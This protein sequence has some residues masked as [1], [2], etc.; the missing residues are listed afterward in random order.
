V[1]MCGLVC[2]VVCGCEVCVGMCGVCLVWVGGLLWEGGC[3]WL[4]V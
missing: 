2:G 4:C 3:G 1:C